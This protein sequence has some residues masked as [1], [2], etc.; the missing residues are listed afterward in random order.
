M[1]NFPGRCYFT[2]HERSAGYR[3]FTAEMEA[4][5]RK[6]VEGLDHPIK[7]LDL[8]VRPGRPTRVRFELVKHPTH[9]TLNVCPSLQPSRGR[10]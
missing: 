10:P 4:H 3:W 5:D 7:G 6:L 1:N 8:Y 2:K 9:G